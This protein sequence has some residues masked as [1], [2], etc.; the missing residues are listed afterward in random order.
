MS[1]TP[2]GRA[3]LPADEFPLFERA[4]EIL[5]EVTPEMAEPAIRAKADASRSQAA[6]G[7]RIL[8]EAALAA[9]SEESRA[10]ITGWAFEPAFRAHG[11]LDFNQHVADFI[12]GDLSTH[13]RIASSIDDFDQVTDWL[14][15]GV[16]G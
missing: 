5:R 9:D 3:A 2:V 16:P 15:N 13:D 11:A 1:F 12:G 4:T 7:I 14:K 10:L 8:T 6:E